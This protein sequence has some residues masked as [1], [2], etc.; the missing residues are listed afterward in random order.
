MTPAIDQVVKTA[1]AK[2]KSDR[3]A[4]H[5]RHAPRA[6]AGAQRRGGHAGAE[7]K[8]DPALPASCIGRRRPA[9]AMPS[10]AQGRAPSCRRMRCRVRGG[11]RCRRGGACASISGGVHRAR[12]RGG[13]TLALRRPGAKLEPAVA[14][15]PRP[16]PRPDDVAAPAAP[17]AAPSPG[18]AAEATRPSRRRRCARRSASRSRRRRKAGQGEGGEVAPPSTKRERSGQVVSFRRRPTLDA[19][20]A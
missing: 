11:R 4:E 16:A 14:A 20:D 17:P 15:V 7:L 9:P 1:L 5:A 19:A 3:F 12:R 2:K 10:T 18:L 8:T 13:I 6:R